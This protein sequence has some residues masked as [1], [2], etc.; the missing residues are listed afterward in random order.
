MTDVIKWIRGKDAAEL[1]RTRAKWIGG[2]EWWL[3]D[4]LLAGEIDG[5][6]RI[7]NLK[8]NGRISATSVERDWS[9]P[10]MVWKKDEMSSAFNLAREIF[11][12]RAHGIGYASVECIGLSF[13]SAQ[14]INLAGVDMQA[15]TTENAAPM[16]LR[17]Q[18]GKAGAH[19]NS[20][21]WA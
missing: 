16:E 21:K 17:T 14:I 10:P 20:K 18:S 4:Y 6:A 13:N 8:S 3:R 11:S 15:Q 1:I 2:P 19:P 9:I 7:A 12:T 5:K